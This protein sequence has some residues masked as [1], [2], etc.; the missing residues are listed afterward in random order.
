MALRLQ[1]SLENELEWNPVTQD[2]LWALPG[3]HLGRERRG[4]AFALQ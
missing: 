1:R 3:A 2:Q 4:A